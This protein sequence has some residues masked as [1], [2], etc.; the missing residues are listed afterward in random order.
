ML[1]ALEPAD[2]GFD[3]GP[4]LLVFLQEV[5]SLPDQRVLTLPQGAVFL[6]EL[7]ADRDQ[8]IESLFEPFQFLPKGFIRAV[9]HSP[10][11]VPG[12]A[13]V[14]CAA[15]GRIVRWALNSRAPLTTMASGNLPSFDLVDRALRQLGAGANAA[16]AHGSL[17]GL[18][19]VL[20]TDATA[21]WVSTLL[22]GDTPLDAAADPDAGVLTDLAVATCTALTGDD[23]AFSPLL[24][25]DDRPLA[26]RADGLAEWCAGF[27][28]GLGEAVGSRGA[29]DALANDMTREIMEDFDEITRVALGE[30]EAGAEAEEAYAELVEFVR[31][32]VQLLFE[33]FCGVRQTAAAATVH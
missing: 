11:I 18:T 32:S 20:G 22:A 1:H 6:L 29:G 27:M 23:M 33:E 30:D 13:M 12:L 10:N 25:P 21:I 4:Y 24:P 9:S 19:C 7:I 3:P 8:V 14:K 16:E 2:H 17:C 26:S 15:W 31:V 5:G 28:Q